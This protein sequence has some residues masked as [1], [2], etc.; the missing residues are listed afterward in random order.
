MLQPERRRLGD[1][2]LSVNLC[3]RWR[4]I[5]DRK[6]SNIA[7]DT[8]SQ[9]VGRVCWSVSHPVP[10][11]LGKCSAMSLLP[12]C[13]AHDRASRSLILLPS[14]RRPPQGVAQ[15]RISRPGS[16]RCGPRR[17]AHRDRTKAIVNAVVVNRGFNMYS[18][19]ENSNSRD[20]LIA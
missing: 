11:V 19:G 8:V 4:A 13:P 12:Q 9:G 18:R 16:S 3:R 10:V 6:A 14:Y 20:A 5:Q 2:P 1:R 17:T 15:I 7:E